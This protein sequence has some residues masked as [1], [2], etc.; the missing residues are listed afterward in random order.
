MLKKKLGVE[1]IEL[2]WYRKLRKMK[3]TDR[4]SDFYKI[5]TTLIIPDG[6]KKV[7]AVAFHCCWRL[8]KVIIPES[9]ERIEEQ[10][11]YYCSNATIILKKSVRDIII[12][13]LAFNYCSKVSSKVKRSEEVL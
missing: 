8:K 6:C 9:V 1:A 10:A 7:G 13:Q 4:I 12:E 11:F 5:P 3:Y 2:N